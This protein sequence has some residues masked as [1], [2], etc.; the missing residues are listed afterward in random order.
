MQ[1]SG[2]PAFHIFFGKKSWF[3]YQVTERVE[4]LAVEMR[5]VIEKMGDHMPERFL[6]NN[7]LLAAI[8]AK[9]AFYDRPAIQAILLFT[10]WDV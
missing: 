5:N 2:P 1:V 8:V 9:R 6:W 10:V 7:V 3:K 4:E